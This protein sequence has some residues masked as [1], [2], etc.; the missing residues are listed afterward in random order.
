MSVT[1]QGLKASYTEAIEVA[2]GPGSAIV[3]RIESL[4]AEVNDPVTGL[5]ATATAVDLLQTKVTTLD[6]VVTATA[7]SVT[8]LTATV[9]NFSAS[10]LFRTTVEATPA[11]ALARIGLSV[12]AS[13]NGTTSQAAIFLDALTGGQSRIVMNADQLIL[14]N[15][16]NSKAPFTFINGEATMM[17]GRISE[18]YSG[19]IRSFANNVVFN[20]DAGTLI[21]SDNT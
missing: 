20:L 11:G 15:G 13:G 14:T 5:T 9:G 18:I 21:F 10:G 17:I 12:A 16:T 4:E 6:G 3:T 8:A 7:N 2:I 19:I 1:A